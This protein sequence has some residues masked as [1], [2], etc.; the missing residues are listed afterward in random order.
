MFLSL[1]CREAF[2]GG[3]A[4]GGKSQSLLMAA[5]QFVH[6][7]SYSAL[8]LR[9]DT[10]R[11]R[12]PG[13]LIPR[14]HAWLANKGPTWNASKDQWSFETGAAPATISFGYLRDSTDKFRYGSSEY[15]FI[16]FDELTEFAEEDYLF[17]FSRLRRRLDINVPL[18]VR[19]ASNPGGAGHDW[20]KE[21]FV[22]DGSLD[23]KSMVY[24]KRGAA[25]V[26]ARLTDNAGVGP[27][28]YAQSL[29]HLPLVWRERMLHGDWEVAEKG[30]VNHNW[31][32]YYTVDGSML[33]LLDAQSVL[34]VELDARTLRR[35]VTIDPAMTGDHDEEAGS[36]SSATAIQVWEHSRA[37]EAPHLILRAAYH[38]RLAFDRLLARLREI[39][40]SYDP[41]V[42]Y[43]ENEKIG[44]AAVS[45]LKG[46]IPLQLVKN[47]GK[48]K[49]ER[50]ADLL[51][52]LERGEVF[53]P[54]EK[55]TGV[56]RLAQELLRWNG[57][58]SK[59]C[60]QIDAAAYA[61]KLCLAGQGECK[62][63]F[64]W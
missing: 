30:I 14:S 60:D 7:P 8:I 34:F 23:R 13:G 42:M 63:E 9:R 11:L 12:L 29:D 52:K 49:I 27:Q 62:M 58:D 19:S 33:R 44:K 43:I 46:K 40:Q 53:I 31:F 37:S 18:R 24:W 5:L 38:E 35:M 4:A 59:D 47:E 3:A 61:A 39:H 50:A 17:L 2:Y 10:Q 32:R 51:R 36:R 22:T 16:G 41:D 28:E 26:P 48:S 57:R 15:Q 6:V 21:R 56:A 54:Q 55:S 25:F 45:V 64:V 1:D 20:V